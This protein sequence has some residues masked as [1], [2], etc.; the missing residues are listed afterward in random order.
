M[1]LATLL[2]SGCA[3]QKKIA[4]IP[5]PS[6]TTP[7]ITTHA[8]PS[9]QHSDTATPPQKQPDDPIEEA[10]SALIEEGTTPTKSWA[11]LSRTTTL[12]IIDRPRHFL[13]ISQHLFNKGQYEQALALLTQPGI[14]T[15]KSIEHS[16]RLLLLG[17]IYLKT[18]NT[19]TKEPRHQ[20]PSTRN[21]GISLKLPFGIAFV[22]LLLSVSGLIF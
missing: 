7:V 14:F 18:E 4:K 16:Q 10:G 21:Q 20:S 3:S 9:A 15:N 22:G 19:N 8:P 12:P 13:K 17:Q 11:L 6:A 1:L 5:R 2:F